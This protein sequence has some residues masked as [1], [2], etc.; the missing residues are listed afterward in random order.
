MKPLALADGGERG[1]A[2]RR[3]GSVV[4]E[5]KA[6]PARPDAGCI[7]R[8]GQASAR[9]GCPRKPRA[10]AY[11]AAGQFWGLRS[12]ISGSIGGLA[13]LAIVSANS[14]WQNSTMLRKIRA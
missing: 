3:P 10:A 12:P 14:V 6:R 4:A 5:R 11:S 8:G 9:Q 2:W 13:M 1:P 7:C